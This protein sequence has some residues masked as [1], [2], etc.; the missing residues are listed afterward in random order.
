[1]S[2]LERQQQVAVWKARGR[3]GRERAKAKRD[4]A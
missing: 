2:I 1:M 4:E 3:A